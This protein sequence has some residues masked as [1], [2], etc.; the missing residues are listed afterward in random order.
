MKKY[1]MVLC[2]ILLWGLGV[3][4]LASQY[5]CFTVNTSEKESIQLLEDIN[6]FVVNKSEGGPSFGEFVKGDIISLWQ[7]SGDNVV[8]GYNHSYVNLEQ[9]ELARVEGGSRNSL[10]LHDKINLL[11]SL[12]RGEQL[13]IDIQPGYFNEP[14][15]DIEPL[16]YDYVDLQGAYE[17]RIVC[18]EENPSIDKKL[19]NVDVVLNERQ[20][21]NQKKAMNCILWIS[22]IL[23]LLIIPAILLLRKNKKDVFAKYACVITL[24]IAASIILKAFL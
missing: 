1:L 12:T 3:I 10:S 18:T 23:A 5:H 19:T 14:M 15:Y 11:K 6:V 24:L 16:Y 20:R 8:I 7:V 2:I 22:V 13:D 21:E 17:G 4:I 9:T